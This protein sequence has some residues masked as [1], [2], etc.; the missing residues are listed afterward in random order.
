MDKVQEEG[1][2]C[3]LD[4]D[5]QGVKSLKAIGRR[6]QYR[7][8][9]IAPPSIEDLETRLRK[10]YVLIHLVG[11]HAASRNT[12]SEGDLRRRLSSSA[13]ELEYGVKPGNFDKVLAY[14]PCRRAQLL[15]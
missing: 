2:V 5:V 7:S 8:I 1:K 15:T 14:Y 3:I 11:P 9:F 10:R 13:K 6:F 12:E 4:V